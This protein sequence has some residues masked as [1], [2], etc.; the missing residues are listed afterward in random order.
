MND[1]RKN[2]HNYNQD[3]VKLAFEPYLKDLKQ[4][5]S[6]LNTKFN[7]KMDEDRMKKG[8][9]CFNERSCFDV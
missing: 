4:S 9:E 8:K 5:I 2:N 7:T 1:S 3:L 6:D